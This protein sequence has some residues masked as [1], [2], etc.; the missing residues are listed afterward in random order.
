METAGRFLQAHSGSFF[1][2]GPRGTGKST[3]LRALRDQAIW[4]DM[5]DPE[6]LRLFQARPER[7][8]E[9]VAAQQLVTDVVIDEVQK[10]PALLDVV[11]KLIEG[12]RPLRFILTGSSARKLRRGAANLLAGRLTELQM[13]PFMAAELGDAFDLQRA[14]EV[15]LVPLVWSAAVPENTLRAYASLYLQE[16]VQAEALVR[17]V[18]AFAR[19][20]EAISFSHGSLL[21][22]SEVARECQVGR[23]TV[24]GYLEI[25][26]DLLLSFRVPVFTR[27]A[28]RHLVAHDKFFYFDAGVYHSIRPKGPL[29]SSEEIEGMA[30]EGLI[31]QHLRAWASYR[32]IP[33]QLYY[34]RTKSGSEVDF[35]MYGA[36][37]F[38]AIEVKRSRHVH[39]TDLRALKA[40]QEDYP[41]AT[42]CLLYMGQEEIKINDVLCLPCDSF[43]QKLRP[44]NPIF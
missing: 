23:K 4:I 25:L 19:F 34:W 14:L 8:M 20:L 32:S 28:K 24:E 15:G 18:G 7:L 27:R 31:A 21:N 35:V 3:W 29:D 40:F 39:H 26:E 12:E 36:D 11:H 38:V 30:L 43:L 6:T 9:R 33:A 2:F 17:N 22:L 13:H 1:L 10:V 42:V 44:I 16:E 5:L 37:V 41:E